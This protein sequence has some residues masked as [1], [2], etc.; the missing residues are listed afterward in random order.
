ML[1]LLRYSICNYCTF[2][3][4]NI[5]SDLSWAL[6][7]FSLFDQWMEICSWILLGWGKV[8]INLQNFSELFLDIFW[9]DTVNRAY[10]V[11]KRLI[12]LI[13]HSQHFTSNL[14]RDERLVNFKAYYRLPNHPPQN[15]SLI[16]WNWHLWLWI[17][18]IAANS[19]WPRSA[20]SKLAIETGFQRDEYFPVML[21]NK[22]F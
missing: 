9:W 7:S 3:E 12:F 1:F 4:I 5:H 10:F 13:Q 14:V 21:K 17:F 2:I 20:L 15:A 16:G 19:P 6:D 8:F 18:W 11:E 22:I